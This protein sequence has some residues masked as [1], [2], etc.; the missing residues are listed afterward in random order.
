MC[1]D[2]NLFTEHKLNNEI[3]LPRLKKVPQTKEGGDM[4]EGCYL[5]ENTES[6]WN[7]YLVYVDEDCGGLTGETFI[8]VKDEPVIFL[9]DR[10]A[11]ESARRV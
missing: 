10:D 7:G 4:C 11:E 6:C 8:F 5:K 3:N 9:P 1:S 2:L